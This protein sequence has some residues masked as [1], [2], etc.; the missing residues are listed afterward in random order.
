M[1][2][3]CTSI[4]DPNLHEIDMTKSKDKKRYRS[5]VINE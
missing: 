3:K 4:E 2:N 5:V 1:G